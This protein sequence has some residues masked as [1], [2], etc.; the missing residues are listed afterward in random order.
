[1]LLLMSILMSMKLLMHDYRSLFVIKNTIMQEK[2]INVGRQ[3]GIRLVFPSI[4]ISVWVHVF[5][6]L[7]NNPI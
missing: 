4:L 5:R 2:R 1:M 3:I 7:E 6:E